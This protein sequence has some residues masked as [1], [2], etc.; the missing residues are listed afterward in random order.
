M[1]SDPIARIL[2]FADATVAR[3]DNL[4]A[5][6]AR[7]LARV[8]RDTE[9]R[10]LP[11]LHQAQ[12]GDQTS[13]LQAAA[14]N[15]VR[16]ELRS[17]LRTAGYDTLADAATSDPLDQ[18]AN[19]VLQARRIAN[20]SSDLTADASLRLEAFR[21]LHFDD[22][23]SAGDDL[24]QQLSRA[25]AR[26]VFGTKPIR[27]IVADMGD[28]VDRSEQTIRTVYDTAISV[29]GR[30]V[31]AIQ[32]G[33]DPETTF[34]YVGPVDDQTREF[35]M[36]HVGRVYTRSEIDDLDNG[37]IDNVFLTGGG[38]NCRHVWQEVSGF[39]ALQ[40]LAGTNKRIPEVMDAVR[41]VR[42]A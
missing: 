27:E 40:A 29:Y 14:S 23:L 33:D 5:R 18:I 13:V 10:L 17:I 32:A 6:F 2:S 24:S 11:L 4:S 36:N 30:E 39:S 7:E 37:Q 28:V 38:Y 41:Q 31:E 12:A 3:A 42:A 19:R 34:A 22:L 21:A 1:A 26:S 8:L 15:R 16:N 35:C 25:V 9:R 20:V